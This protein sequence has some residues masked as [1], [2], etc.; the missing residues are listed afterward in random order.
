MLRFNFG[1]KEVSELFLSIKAQLKD[2]QITDNQYITI[3]NFF[4]LLN[5]YLIAFSLIINILQS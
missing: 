4:N 2:I 1:K 5:P 3:N